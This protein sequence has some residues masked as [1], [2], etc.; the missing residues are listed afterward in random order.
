MK[1][2]SR[3]RTCGHRRKLN[4]HP[5]EYQIQ[6]RC[7]HCGARDWRQDKYRHRVEVPQM[8]AKTGRYRSCHC[9]GYHFAHRIGFGACKYRRDGELKSASQLEYDLLRYAKSD[10]QAEPLTEDFPF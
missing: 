8:R 9:D 5:N 7:N 1:T 3:C 6:P 2:H 10:A 4:R